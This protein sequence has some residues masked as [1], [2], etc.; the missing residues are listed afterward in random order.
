MLTDTQTDSHKQTI[1]KTIQPCCAGGNCQ[2]L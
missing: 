2:L 1:L